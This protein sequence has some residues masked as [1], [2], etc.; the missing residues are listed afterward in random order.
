M[1]HTFRYLV[2]LRSATE[3]NFRPHTDQYYEAGGSTRKI[4]FEFFW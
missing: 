3:T 2:S 4:F 1:A